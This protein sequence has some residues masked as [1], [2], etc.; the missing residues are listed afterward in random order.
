MNQNKEVSEFIYKEKYLQAGETFEEG[1]TRIAGALDDGEEHFRTLREILL[2][3]RFLPAGRIQVAVGAT[4]STTPYNCFVSGTIPDSMEGICERF[5][6]SLQ[7]MRL[8]GGI[9]YDFSTLRPAGEHIA[10]VDSSS[11]GPVGDE[12]RSKG[13]MD[14]F[15][16]G[17][18]VI[19]S[20]GHRRGAQM[21]VLRVD[22]PDIRHFVHCKR[23]PGRLT[24][25]NISVGVTDEFMQRVSDDG[26]FDLVFDGR[27]YETIRARNLWD[28]IMRSTWDYAEP[29]VLYLDTINRKNNLWYCEDIVATNPCAE[30]PLPPFGACLLGS[31]NLTK[32]I[33]DANDTTSLPYNSAHIWRF[34]WEQFK[35]DIPPVVRAMDNVID[36]AIY[37]LP[38]QEREAK[39]KRRMGLGITGLANTAE[40]LGLPYG[41]DRMVP[42]MEKVLTTLRDT[43]YLSSTSLAHEKG[44]FEKYD[45]LNMLSGGFMRSLPQYLREAM[46]KLGLRNSHLLSIAPTGTISLAANNISSGIEPPY[47]TGLYSRNVHQSNGSICSFDLMDFAESE[48]GVV[49]VTSDGCSVEDH[50][51]VLNLASKYVDSSVSKTCNV[52]PHVTFNEFKEVYQLA[53]EGGAS[54]LTTF[55]PAEYGGKREGILTKKATPTEDGAAHWN[56]KD[57]TNPL[58]K[59]GSACFIDETGNRSC[60]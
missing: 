8:G 39:S 20:A 35:H 4:R 37:P 27:V 26:E 15:D 14:M 2:D 33:Y 25:F 43:A 28:E 10:S 50:V 49:G 22:H 32:Y 45:K 19:S 3:Q 56:N 55:R 29:G 58:T 5:T 23:T 59:V 24:A 51:R 11:C 17:G 16:A 18:A 54:G 48:Y 40:I 21:A 1:M 44:S 12:H 7:T 60:D 38:E 46:W 36:R 31:F 57:E 6:E 34:N 30:Q 42:F 52:G 9:G 41:S 53:Y 47:T 13:F